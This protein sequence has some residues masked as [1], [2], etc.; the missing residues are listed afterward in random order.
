MDKRVVM[1]VINGFSSR[2][3]ALM[4]KLWRLQVVVASLGLSL[5]ATWLHSV[6][7]VW[8]DELLRTHDRAEFTLRA[9]VGGRLKVLWGAPTVDMFA[10]VLK[11]RCAR[12]YSMIFSP[13]CEGVD[14]FSVD[15]GGPEKRWVYSPF[16]DAR[17]VIAKIRAEGAT[18][19]AILRVWQAQ[20]WW[21]DAVGTAQSA[22]L[23]LVVANVLV[24][25]GHA[26]CPPP[27]EGNPAPG[28][29]PPISQ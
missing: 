8:A 6:A 24:G 13:G 7:N 23:L 12:F 16:S 17:R 27:L 19:T 1:H 10:S 9:E 4:A 14:A 20:Y 28:G 18:A 15:W 11:K 2:S 25:R 22:Y 5:T 26:A 3:P 29:T 21:G